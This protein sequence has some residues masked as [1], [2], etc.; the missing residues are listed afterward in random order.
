MRYKYRLT[1]YDPAKRNHLGHFMAEDWTSIS[2]IGK[3]F[4][5]SV[6][7][8]DQYEAT[9]NAY[10]QVIYEF[11]RES[12]ITEFQI[13]KLEMYGDQFKFELDQ[14]LSL[15]YSIQIARLAL[16]EELWCQLRAPRWGYLHFGYD[17][18]VYLAVPKPCPQ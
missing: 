8:P 16:R 14:V 9:E 18:Y 6:L 11:A 1:K 13:Q 4:N 5:G 10:L 15:D 2:D 3:S 17:F 12:G 7:T